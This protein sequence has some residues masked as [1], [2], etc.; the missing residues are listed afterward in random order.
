VTHPGPG[1]GEQFREIDLK[2]IECAV[3]AASFAGV[4][5]FVYVSVAHPAPVM[6]D[7]IA[8]RTRGEQLIQDA[9]LKAT[10][11]RPWYVLGPGHWWPYA[12]LPAY[13]LM[14]A[15]PATRLSARRLGLVTH[16]EMVGALLGAVR[17][18][19]KGISIMNVEEIRR[20]GRTA[21]R[22]SGNGADCRSAG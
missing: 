18:P 7:Y 15:I 2:S 13:W 16:R 14:D 3:Q 8:V 11:L 5:H 22:A 1:K 9:G 19:A 17:N 10:I 21:V 6:R 4:R 12:L 20:L